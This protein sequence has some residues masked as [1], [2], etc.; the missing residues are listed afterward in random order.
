MRKLSENNIAINK[1]DPNS[2]NITP[3]ETKPNPLDTCR[4]NE[5]SC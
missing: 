2:E 4:P 1:I 3:N 5:V